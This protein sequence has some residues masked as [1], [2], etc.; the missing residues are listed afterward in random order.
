MNC[1]VI[2]GAGG[3]SP[4]DLP[5]KKAGDLWIAADGGQKHLDQ[6]GVK[7]DLF[8]GDLDSLR[9]AP[10]ETETTILPRRK[11][12]TDT[13][14]AV[15]EGLRRGYRRFLILGALGG[16]R[17][18]HT[19]AN[20]QLLAYLKDHSA[21]GELKDGNTSV[22]L[23][24]AGE[25][26]SFRKKRGFFSLFALSP[27]ARVAVKGALFSGEDIVLSARFPLGVSNEFGPDTSVRILEGDVFLVID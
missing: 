18:S 2:V 16:R 9:V 4:R 26:K 19:V 20:F 17:L 14:A 10:T 5:E 23:L 21:E 13:V 11:D 24:S 8:L 25:E 6:A 7:A 12:D 3:F 27:E 1:C 15:K 22:T